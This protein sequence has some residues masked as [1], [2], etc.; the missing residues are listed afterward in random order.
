MTPS[1]NLMSKLT[2]VVEA[3]SFQNFLVAVILFN[4]VTLGLETTQFGKDNALL[5]HKIDTVI[6]LIFTLELLLKLIVYRLKFFKSGWNCFDFIIVA[7]SWIP[8]GG[9]LSVLR[10]FRI[11]R[12]LRLFSIVPQMRRVIGALG[13]SLPGMASVIG[14][15]GI[16]FYVSAVLTTKLFG[17]HPDPNMQEWFG[18]LGAS[19]YTLFQVM[20]LESWSMGIVRPTMELF[21]E[22]WLFFVPFIIITS[23]A[24]LNLF[25]GIIV[26]A[27]QVMHDEEVKTE[28]MSATKEDIDRLEAKLDE[29]LKQ[30]KHD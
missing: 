16:V 29:L 7:I 28:Q 23:F 5:L 30:K 24:V 15:L 13:H 26:D 6:L 11:L 2:S 22:S 3:K 10:A 4:A 21:P 18:S 9:A 19:A 12:V 27:M 20:T 25:I 14:V 8:A 1:N 17:Q